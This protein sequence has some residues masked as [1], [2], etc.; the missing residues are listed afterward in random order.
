MG[1]LPSMI[2]KKDS[3]VW[4]SRPGIQVEGEEQRS[5]AHLHTHRDLELREG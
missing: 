1:W 5:E 4:R 3:K 2:A